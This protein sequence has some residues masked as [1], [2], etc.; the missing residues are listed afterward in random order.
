MKKGVAVILFFLYLCSTTEVYQLL[1]IPILIEHYQW[2]KQLDPNLTF[3]SFI[4]HHYNEQTK[5]ADWQTDQKLPFMTHNHY[6]ISSFTINAPISIEVK[7]SK[8][9]ILSRKVGLH[10]DAILGLDKINSIWQPPKS[11]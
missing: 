8:P 6:S 9:T 4:E 7:E 11:C 5:D 10:N 3:Y 1:K 2:H